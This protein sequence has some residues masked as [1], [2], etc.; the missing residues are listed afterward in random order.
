MLLE[1][2]H[3]VRKCV[4]DSSQVPNPGKV[5]KCGTGS[6]LTPPFEHLLSYNGDEKMVMGMLLMMKV[7]MT[8]MIRTIAMMMIKL[9]TRSPLTPPSAHL[10]SQAN[11]RSRAVPANNVSN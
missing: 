2:F 8:W 6:P 5:P 7:T 3:K 9:S 1:C 10:L 4:E 11:S